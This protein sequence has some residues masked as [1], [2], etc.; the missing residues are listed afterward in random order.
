MGIG[1]ANASDFQQWATNEGLSNIASSSNNTLIGFD[2]LYNHNRMVYGINTDIELRNFDKAEPYYFSFTLRAGYKWIAQSGFTM[3]TL[4]G[5]GAGYANIRFENGTP[6]AI[7]NLDEDYNDPFARAS[8]LV[9]R[10]EVIGSYSFKAS[11][12]KK[13]N[14]GIFPLLY[15]NAGVTPTLSHYT[16][17]YGEISWDLN[18]NNNFNGQDI[19]IPRFYKGIFRSSLTH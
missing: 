4:G 2:F 16:W 1:Y 15:F 5:I 17:R 10:L 6:R 11:K 9:G 3:K 18:R 13:R 8:M 7:E 19:D 14:S 12:G